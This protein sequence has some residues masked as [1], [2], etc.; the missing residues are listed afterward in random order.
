MLIAASLVIPA[1]SAAWAQIYKVTDGD[2]G[3]I[4]TDKP[5]TVGNNQNQNVEEVQLQ[6]LNTAAPIEVRPRP[7]A[8]E[9]K[10]KN[11][12]VPAATVSITSPGNEST[13]AMGPGNFS[14]SATA[15]PPLSRDERLTLMIDGQAYGTAQSSSSWF[16]EGA[17]RGPHDLVVQRSTTEGKTV[18]VSEAVRIYVLRPSIIGR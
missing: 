2:K 14:V 1:S 7:P 5:E 12:D 13:V 8:P 17:L 6:E 3:V 11:D 18:A 10:E 4:F 16:V 15:T 9:G